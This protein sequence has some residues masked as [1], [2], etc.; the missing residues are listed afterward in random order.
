VALNKTLLRYLPIPRPAFGALRF[1]FCSAELSKFDTH[2]WRTAMKPR[3]ERE[4]AAP[5]AIKAMRALESYD[6]RLRA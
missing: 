2:D 5:G 3:I 6:P 4:K 1:N